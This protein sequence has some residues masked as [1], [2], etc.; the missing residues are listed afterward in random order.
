MLT[1]ALAKGR[2]AEMTIARFAAAGYNCGVIDANSRKLI[3]ENGDSRFLMAKPS[4]VPTY[5]EY[6]A[7][8]AG[9][10]GKDTLLE[11]RRDLYEVF[12]FGFGRCEMVV[13]GPE[14]SFG[15]AE[16]RLRVATKYP[17]IASGY[18]Q[19]RGINAEIIKLNG[20]LELAPASGLADVIVDITETGST[21]RENNLVIIDSIMPLSAR[22]IVN[23]VSM[24][25]KYERIT[26][27]IRKLKESAK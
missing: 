1:F 27:L 19:S 12:D 11:E 2:L 3:F 17:S 8:D 7:A 5:V 21:L 22:L 9:V 14:K 23:R 20:S 4:D 24:K 25:L 26:E 10:A 15:T 13:A 18:F 6:G 16:A